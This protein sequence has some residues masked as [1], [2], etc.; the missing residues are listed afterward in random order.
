V[1]EGRELR[2]EAV[3]LDRLF[4][5]LAHERARTGVGEEVRA[6]LPGV[7]LVDRNDDGADRD[8]CVIAERPLEPRTAE[9]GDTVARLDTER[10]KP[11]RQLVNAPTGLAPPDLPPDRALLREKGGETGVVRRRVGPECRDRCADR[12]TLENDPPEF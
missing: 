11:R 9:D 8:Q 6:F 5:V 4:L 7:R 2:V 1:L 12:T 10:E 3:G